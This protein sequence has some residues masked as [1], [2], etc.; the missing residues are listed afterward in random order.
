MI[1]KPIKD[2]KIDNIVNNSKDYQMKANADDILRAFE[3]KK[4]TAPKV[5]IEQVK[6]KTVRYKTPAF[7]G[8]MAFASI[9]IVIGVVLPISLNMNN[10]GIN[11]ISNNS[12]ILTTSESSKAISKELLLFNLNYSDNENSANNVLKKVSKAYEN[13][14]EFTLFDN[15]I[16]NIKDGFNSVAQLFLNNIFSL[17]EIEITETTLKDPKMIGGKQFDKR[18][19]YEYGKLIGIFPV[20]EY[21]YY[22]SS[23]ENLDYGYTEI[24]VF[25]SKPLYFKTIINEINESGNS[26]YETTFEFSSD[27]GSAFKIDNKQCNDDNKDIFSYALY[28][29]RDDLTINK[30]F[31]SFLI[32]FG[33]DN[34][35]SKFKLEKWEEYSIDY[36]NI[37]LTGL[38]DLSFEVEYLDLLTEKIFNFDASLNHK[39]NKNNYIINEKK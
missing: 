15:I 18:I 34:M 26:H 9:A 12:Q 27:T 11:N 24:P 31:K 25:L 14:S 20:V 3:L 4:A 5:E 8:S 39:D 36:L 23:I 19:D 13:N 1:L 2:N 37:S 22:Y 38:L 7:A 21:S 6:P 35:D 33:N 32:Q 10:S 16:D 28:E 30:Y 29:N 17:D